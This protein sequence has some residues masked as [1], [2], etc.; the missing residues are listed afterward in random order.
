MEKI[1]ILVFGNPLVQRDNLAL[2][3]V[4]ELKVNFPNINFKEFD[5]TEDLHKQGREL[6]IMDVVEGIDRVK[7][8]SF[9]PEST[10]RLE[11]NKPF[12]LH[13]FDL[14]HNL[15]ILKK[16]NMI[17]KA[18]ILGI[19]PKLSKEEAVNQSQL[20]LRKWVAQLMQGS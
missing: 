3:I 7:L 19:P 20:I 12:S 16:M 8:I 14:A 11:M 6:K 1:N 9:P 13:D 5:P 4:P 15:K 10:N 18:E 2:K 17:D